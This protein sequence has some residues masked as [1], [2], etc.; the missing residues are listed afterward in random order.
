ML[1]FILTTLNINVKSV[2]SVCEECMEDAL[3]SHLM[4]MYSVLQHNLCYCKLQ[5]LVLEIRTLTLP[6]TKTTENHSLD[7]VKKYQCGNVFL[8]Y[9]SKTRS[10]EMEKKTK[11]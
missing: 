10:R 8:I 7:V 9:C 1:A 6:D 4:Q 5:L 2:W 3:V 11:K